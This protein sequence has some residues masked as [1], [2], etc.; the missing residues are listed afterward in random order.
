MVLGPECNIDV[1]RLGNDISIPRYIPVWQ[2]HFVIRI[3]RHMMIAAGELDDRHSSVFNEIDLL[4]PATILRL[5]QL[6]VE[7]I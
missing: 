6:M 1:N 5:Y 2:K 4:K 7:R 3:L